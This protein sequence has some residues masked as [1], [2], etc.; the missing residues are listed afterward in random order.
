MNPYVP[1]LSP[2]A[3]RWAR[4]FAILAALL[5]LGWLAHRLRSVL[6]PLAVGFAIAYILNPVIV[7]LE[8]RRLPRLAATSMTFVLI[9]GSA[10]VALGL[11][12][13]LGTVQ[14]IALAGNAPGYVAGAQDWLR[15]HYPD[16]L[17][18]IGDP[19]Q[20]T[21]LAKEHGQSVAAQLGA[22]TAAAFGGAAQWLSFGLLVPLYGFFF[23]WKFDAI[24]A[25]V[26]NHLP[27]AYRPVIE[28][29]AATADR[30]IA[31]FFRGR[32]IICAVYGA[33]IGVGWLIVG[34][35]YSLPLGLLAALT[36]LV[37]GLS[38]LALPPALLLTYFDAAHSGVAWVWPVAYCAAVYFAAQAVESFLLAPYVMGQSSGLHPITTVVV[39]LI[40][41]ELAG[42]LGVLLA[43]PAAGTLKSLAGEFLMPE[44]RR[45]A[46][47]P[48]GSDPTRE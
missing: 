3:A 37:P 18:R 24:I 12:T 22:W 11:L 20:M 34:T 36:N 32:L 30:S 29:V 10:I 1:E 43:I 35:P 39:L 45:L 14:L 47:Q 5:L 15:Q 13:Y 25:V 8:R 19:H 16:L 7:S 2:P 23:L 40:G 6:T 48:R 41:A 4:F 33:L 38:V 42:L 9:G 17:S 21:T 46:A 26:R 44:I 27:A 31:E 28:R